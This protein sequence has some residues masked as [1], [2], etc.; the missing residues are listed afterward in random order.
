[1][2]NKMFAKLAAVVLAVA[3]LIAS[4]VPAFAGGKDQTSCVKVRDKATGLTTITCP[5]GSWD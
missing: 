2:A 3:L 4:T 1:M 5:D